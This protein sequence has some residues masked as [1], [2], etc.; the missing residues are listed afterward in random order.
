MQ[1]KLRVGQAKGL[2]CKGAERALRLQS[3]GGEGARVQRCGGMR[4]F[5][6]GEN[7]PRVS[8]LYPS[9][10]VTAR[11]MWLGF[12]KSASDGRLTPV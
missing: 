7:L 1:L 9:L 4:G 11:S 3:L 10:P 12:S 5:L 6:F 2:A 8:S